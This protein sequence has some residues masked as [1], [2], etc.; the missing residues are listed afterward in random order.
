MKLKKLNPTTNGTRHTIKIQKNLLSKN[1]RL[2][3]SILSKKKSTGGRSSLN[4][5]TTV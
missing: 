2:L 3:R 4:G 5:R 1:N